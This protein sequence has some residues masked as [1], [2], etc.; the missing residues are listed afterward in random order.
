[1]NILKNKVKSIE[2]KFELIGFTNKSFD[3]LSR[4]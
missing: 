3:E 1:M 2:N 4:D